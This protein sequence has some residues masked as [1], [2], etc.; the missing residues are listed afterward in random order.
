MERGYAK[1]KKEMAKLKAIH[2]S[3]GI[4]VSSL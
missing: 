1:N 4:A 2:F 3:D